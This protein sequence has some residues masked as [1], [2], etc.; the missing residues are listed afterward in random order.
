MNRSMKIGL[1][2]VGAL[3]VVIGGAVDERGRSMFVKPIPRRSRKGRAPSLSE[4]T[5]AARSA[6]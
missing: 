3:I 5:S 2:A 6:G 1:G 4:R